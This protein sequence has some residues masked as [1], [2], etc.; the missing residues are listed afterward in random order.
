MSKSTLRSVAPCDCLAIRQAAR[1]ITQLYDRYL[2]REDLRVG[3]YSILRKLSR[4]ESLSINEMALTMVMDATSISRAIK[5]LVRDGLISVSAGRD[6]RSRKL[7]LT[8]AGRAKLKSATVLWQR[9]QNEFEAAFGPDNAEQVRHTMWRV[10][11]SFK[12]SE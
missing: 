6:A 12:T 3:Q 9:A 11:E 1:Q 2:L 4:F 7:E 8:E 10:V 5:P